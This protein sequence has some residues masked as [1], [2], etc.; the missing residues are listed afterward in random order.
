MNIELRSTM[1]IKNLACMDS[2]SFSNRALCD[3]GE[4][5]KLNNEQFAL[6]LWLISRKLKGIDPPPKLTPEMVP[7]SCRKPSEAS[8]A[9]VSIQLFHIIRVF[10]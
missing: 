8:G 7:P 2:C 9:N 3:T 1:H 10:F 4:Q 6:A 5:G